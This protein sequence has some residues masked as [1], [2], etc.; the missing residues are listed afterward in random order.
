MVNF[1]L[2]LSLGEMNKKLI[3]AIF[4]KVANYDKSH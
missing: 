4:Q 1:I 2:I 3:I